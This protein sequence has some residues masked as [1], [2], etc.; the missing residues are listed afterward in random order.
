MAKRRREKVSEDFTLTA[1]DFYTAFVDTSLD[2]H[3]AMM[4]SSSDTV[5][6]LKKKIVQE[7][8]QL[9]PGIGEIKVLSLQ[10]KRQ[11]HFYHLPDSMLVFSAYE[12]SKRHKNLFVDASSPK[13]HDRE[14]ISSEPDNI[15]HIQLENSDEL[16]P[17]SGLA[18]K[19]QKTE[20]N[21]NEVSGSRRLKTSSLGHQI[22]TAV[23]DAGKSIPIMMEIRDKDVDGRKTSDL[24]WSDIAAALKTS[25]SEPAVEKSLNLGMEENVR[26]RSHSSKRKKVTQLA[27]C[28]TDKQES[29]S[30]TNAASEQLKDDQ[31]VTSLGS[32]KRK[33]RRERTSLVPSDEAAI[34]E[35]TPIQDI[36]KEKIVKGNLETGCKNV[37]KSCDLTI[38]PGEG[39]QPETFHR[40]SILSQKGSSSD[41][42]DKV[43]EVSKSACSLEGN[44]DGKISNVDQT[45]E[46]G[47]DSKT[48][49]M[50]LQAA[51]ME[52]SASPA[53]IGL[54]DMN[55]VS[56]QVHGENIHLGSWDSVAPLTDGQGQEDIKLNQDCE[57]MPSESCKALDEGDADRTNEASTLMP[58]LTA[59]SE[60]VGTVTCDGTKR[61]KKKRAKKKAAA[62]QTDFVAE[63]TNM[64]GANP[65]DGPNLDVA[66]HIID[67][68]DKDECTLRT[69]ESDQTNRV[70]E[71]RGL[72]GNV[73][74]LEKTSEC[75]KPRDCAEAEVPTETAVLS[76]NLLRFNE[77]MD[78]GNSTGKKKKRKTKKSAAK[79]QGISEVGY[80][81]NN[82]S[83]ISLSVQDVN[84]SDQMTDCDNKSESQMPGMRSDWNTAIL[85]DKQLSMEQENMM[86][87][88]SG[89]EPQ[90]MGETDININQ[91]MTASILSKAQDVKSGNRRK[92]KRTVKSATINQDDSGKELVD[93]L[94]GRSAFSDSP[95]NNVADETKNSLSILSQNVWKDASKDESMDTCVLGAHSEGAKVIH[96]E[97][98]TEVDLSH[99]DRGDNGKNGRQVHS[100]S[101][102]S[103]DNGI[104]DLPVENQTNEVQRL[105]QNQS[106][107]PKENDCN[108]DGK[109]KKKKKKNQFS[110][111]ENLSTS[112]IKEQSNVAEEL[113]V[114]GNK[115]KVKDIP[116]SAAKTNRLA[117]KRTVIQSTPPV[118][119]LEKNLGTESSPNHECAAED[120]NPSQVPSKGRPE[121]E[122]DNIKTAKCKD[123]GINFK[124]YFVT[125]QHQDK[126]SSSAKVKQKLTKPT[127]KQ[128]KHNVVAENKLESSE[129]HGLQYK[130]DGRNIDDNRVEESASSG[131]NNKALF[132]GNKNTLK[133]PEHGIKVPSSHEAK[134]D[135]T[136][137]KAIKPVVVDGAGTSTKTS[138]RNQ[139]SGFSPNSIPKRNSSSK[140]AGHVLNSSGQKKSSLF[141]PRLVF[142]LNSS[143]S[144]S[145]ENQIV[146]SDAS[147][148]APSDSSSSS[149]YSVGESELRPDS[150][151]NGSVN[152]TGEGGAVGNILDTKFSGPQQMSM[153]MVLRS[154]SR[155]KKAKIAASQSQ[156]GDTGSQPVDFVP[157]SQAKQ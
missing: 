43:L 115:T 130:S 51:V 70:E 99:D 31:P 95:A 60:P 155:F 54:N 30:V 121:S 125:G 65:S 143:E 147:T 79:V 81:L 140:N 97:A 157:D 28:T 80:D 148:R 128:E 142:R 114:S 149:G 123:E 72:S 144:S 146:N 102:N 25:Q 63:Q 90:H 124:H 120:A 109:T 78:V 106:G 59:T 76:S 57:V 85:G 131:E 14:Q 27:S 53:I 62:M 24:Y 20:H 58:K 108:L 5:S 21:E 104:N 116:S 98:R 112:E 13:E 44:V 19:K 117:K 113:A 75:L 26:D 77:A 6:D 67:K 118:L 69:A 8:F 137:K 32:K 96:Y 56:S 129:N 42:I 122:V 22:E 1:E 39:V 16:S 110:A 153:D 3:L 145:N 151:R 139:Q 52:D 10:V 152:A 100:N 46:L 73:D 45:G 50:Q 156:A 135:K 103:V 12:G 82:V 89:S 141:T 111:S 126:V 23:V 132:C 35:S 11:G 41:I 91:S 71:E 150:K 105:Q 64:A 33:K 29:I 2:T 17:E 49:S 87:L 101:I 4:I 92:K 37:D 15:K 88:P 18:A 36:E 66:D 40:P 47:A 136:L 38:I 61:N 119:E 133:A 154:S 138:K 55:K 94:N 9:F 86:S 84:F 93:T 83:G 48:S 34:P 74:P 134:E 107:K 68:T 127:S 7:H